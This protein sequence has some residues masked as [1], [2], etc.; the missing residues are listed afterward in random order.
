VTTTA[1]HGSTS[2]IEE[3]KVVPGTDAEVR[4]AAV[5]RQLA[6]VIAGIETYG[7]QSFLLTQLRHAAKSGLRFSY[8]AAQDGDCAKALRA[9]GAQVEVVGGQIQRFYPGHPLLVLLSWLWWWPDLYRTYSG[10][11]RRLRTTRHDIV[12]AQSYYGLV[13]SRLAARGSGCRVVSHVHSNLNKKRLAGL[14]RILVSL[15]LAVAADRLVTISDFV[16]A[17]LWG[18]A[19]R[20]AWRIYNGIDIHAI[21]EMVRG[22]TKDPRRIVTVGRLVSWKKQEM[23]LQAIKIL[24]ER[25]VDCT[26]EIIGGRGCTDPSD[27]E[28][29]LRALTTKLKIGDRVH[30]SGAVSPPYHRV[31]AAAALVSCS[32]REPFGLAVVEAAACGTAVVA[33]D[34]GATA[35]LIEDGRTGLLFSA[36]DPVSLANAL[37]QLLNNEALR[38]SLAEA[39]LQRAMVLYGISEHLQTLR[40]CFDELLTRR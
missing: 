24:V 30:F 18:P 6:V 13:I 23:A 8:L 20:K 10:I 3:K 14:Q 29:M 9:A 25:G 40:L 36:D 26:L 28:L 37:E 19:R 17:S 21:S 4:R 32:T 22:T 33:A 27:H 35:E 2:V 16:T 39:A 31:A 34:M 5:E 12:Y 38:T 7:I 11:R 15:I 1:G